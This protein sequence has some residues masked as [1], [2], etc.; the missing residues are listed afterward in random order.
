MLHFLSFFL[1]HFSGFSVN[2]GIPSIGV[3]F[4]TVS[5]IELNC[6]SI[7]EFVN[8]NGR[9]MAHVLFLLNLLSLH[10]LSEVVGGNVHLVIPKVRMMLIKSISIITGLK[11]NSIVQ[12]IM[13]DGVVMGV[14]LK[15]LLVNFIH[16]FLKLI[17]S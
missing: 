17:R 5:V 8:V 1:I 2:C 7:I 9:V 4:V 6:N 14:V 15:L 16:L 3:V 13:I 10:F 11:S 12:F